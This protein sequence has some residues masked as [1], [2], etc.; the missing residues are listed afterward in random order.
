MSKV[1]IVTDS[2]ADIPQELVNKYGIIVV[3]LKVTIGN[4]VYRD[5]VDIST[6]EIIKRLE[7]DHGF[8]PATSQPS[9]G[10]FV[11]V[12][13]KLIQKGE[14][15]ISIHLSGKM[16]GTVQSAQTAKTMTDS[17]DIYIVDSK[18]A[19][20]GLG[21]IVIAAAIAA[22]EGKPV[23]E[24]LSIVKE[25]VERSFVLFLVDTLDYLEKGGRIGKA[26]A[27]LGA[28]LKIKPVLTIDEDGQIIPIEKVR[29]KIR[30]IERIA[31]IVADRT[32]SSRY[33]NYAVLHGNDY[34]GFVKLKE[35][36]EKVLRDSHSMSAE[37]GP[38]IL[39]H[40]GP[41]LTGV[42]ICPD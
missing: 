24:I 41:G 16:S 34:S 12:Y 19:S 32:D 40:T 38:V 15:V 29:G 30:A 22:K 39:S 4:Q 28:L 14:Y 5:G 17:R 27:L 20:M 36:L 3:P 2:T 25:K 10:E 26:S 13:E 1:R 8:L 7:K 23:R 37:I 21:L 35:E 33:Y 9:P 11:A 31:Q 6:A 18:S 42:A